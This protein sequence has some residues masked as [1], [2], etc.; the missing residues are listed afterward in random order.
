VLLI[1]FQASVAGLIPLFTVGA[2]LT[3]TFSQAGMVVH[4]RRKRGSGW[5]WRMVVNAFGALTTTVVLCV[6][7]ISKFVY[8]AWIVVLVLPLLVL[9]LRAIGQHHQRLTAQV[10][11]AP[12]DASRWVESNTQRTRHIAIIPVGDSDRVALNAVAFLRTLDRGGGLDIHAVHVTDDHAAGRRLME[13]WNALHI[14][15]PLIV[16]ESPYRESAEALLR[17]IDLLQAEHGA[18]LM[19]LVALPEVL[20]TRWWHPLL[21]N[22]LAWRLK[23]ALLFRPSTSVLSVPYYVKD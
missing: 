2:F 11:V 8:G 22:Y 10:R 12:E 21:H 3:F 7:L 18:E 15:V 1:A 6:V 4:W 14:G 23:W 19:V 13:E 17:Y 20:P 9:M 5:Q 16:L